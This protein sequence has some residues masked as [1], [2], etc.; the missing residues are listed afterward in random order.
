MRRRAA[1]STG[2][3]CRWCSGRPSGNQVQ[4]A[5]ILGIIAADAPAEAPRAGPVRHE[6][7]RGGRGRRRLSPGAGP[8]GTARRQ[9]MVTTS[10]ASR[11]ARTSAAGRP[12]RPSSDRARR[13]LVVA[14]LCPSRPKSWPD[15]APRDRA[16]V[17]HPTLKLHHIR[18]LV[19]E[20]GERLIP[21]GGRRAQTGE[22]ARRVSRRRCMRTRHRDSS[23]T[24]ADPAGP[25][26]GSGWTGAAS[27]HHAA[28]CATGR[29]RRPSAPR[30]PSNRLPLM[31]RPGPGVPVP[32]SH[33]RIVPAM[34]PL[35][36]A[37]RVARGPLA[38]RAG[39]THDDV[40]SCRPSLEGPNS[41]R[42]FVQE[43]QL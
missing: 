7:R 33:R 23:P 24:T 28:S 2:S 41:T 43:F 3:S 42:S 21:R 40:A 11:A 20:S 22:S 26:P 38:R 9:S 19:A 36:P 5:R 34:H 1:S 13:T 14:R 37:R 27:P 35:H 17:L 4:A 12:A 31:G 10:P 25:P 16:D 8:C 6:V 32:G 18:Q 15:D 29:P 39:P 30:C